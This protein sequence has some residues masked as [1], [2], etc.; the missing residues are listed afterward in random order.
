[1]RKINFLGREIQIRVQSERSPLSLLGDSIDE[2]RAARQKG[3]VSVANRVVI[4]GLAEVAQV[5][6]PENRNRL[7]LTALRA[8]LSEA[9]EIEEQTRTKK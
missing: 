5:V 2:A 9:M 4:R 1:M 3:A 8:L 6:D 7:G